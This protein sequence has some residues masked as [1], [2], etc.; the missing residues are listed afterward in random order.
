MTVYGP[1]LAPLRRW[2]WVALLGAIAASIGD[3]LM[4][5]QGL[6]AMPEYAKIAT[7]PDLALLIGY[8]L[9]IAGIPLFGMGYWGISRTFKTPRVAAVFFAVTLIGVASGTLIHSA[10][11]M[12]AYALALSS[13]GSDAT[14]PFTVF[15]AYLI[16][17]VMLSV[18]A[19]L[20][21]AGLYIYAVARGRSLLPRWAATVNP[22]LLMV[23]LIG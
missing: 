23:S 16:P 9:G 21:G 11:G 1:S 12:G 14:G 18:A 5:W 3:G 6:Q 2:V 13:A 19:T 20:I 10:T 4:L 15:S 8:Y 17:L 7:P 22:V